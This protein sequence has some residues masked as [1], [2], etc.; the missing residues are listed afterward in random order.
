MSVSARRHLGVS[1]R[2]AWQRWTS[3]F[4]S[5]T[6]GKLRPAMVRV[7]WH[8][9]ASRHWH[10]CETTRA[11]AE[12]ARTEIAKLSRLREVG[13]PDDLFRDVSPKV[14]RAYRRRAASESPSSLLVHPPGVRYTLLSALCF[15]RLREVT[16]GLVEVLIQIVHK[17][18]ARSEKKI[19]KV[20]LEDFKKVSG[21]HPFDRTTWKVNFS[22]T[23]P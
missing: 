18:G 14:V 16:D 6:Y 21:V 23:R 12:S 4:P 22:R 20:L 9:G 1:Q 11:S 10:A 15:M 2:T 3:C 17:I 7:A 13:L 19:E 5:L 8:R